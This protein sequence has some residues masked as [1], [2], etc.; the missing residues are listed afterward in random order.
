MFF[1]NT[2]CEYLSHLSWSLSSFCLSLFSYFCLLVCLLPLPVLLICHSIF[3]FSHIGRNYP[4]VSLLRVSPVAS[5]SFLLSC[6]HHQIILLASNRQPH[7]RTHTPVFAFRHRIL[8]HT[9]QFA[10]HEKNGHCNKWAKH[11]EDVYRI[12][13][14]HWCTFNIDRVYYTGLEI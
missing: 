4:I 10:V 13:V 1:L 9:S 3:F 8:S 14:I 12:H 7:L 11:L 5:N 2:E 6:R